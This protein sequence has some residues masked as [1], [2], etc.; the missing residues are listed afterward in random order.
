MSKVFCGEC[1]YSSMGE[2]WNK[3]NL[4]DTPLTRGG[5]DRD[6]QDINKNN[7]CSWY[8]ASSFKKFLNLFRGY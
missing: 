7:D 8:E 6:R 5:L 3:K 2:C 1:K 4:K